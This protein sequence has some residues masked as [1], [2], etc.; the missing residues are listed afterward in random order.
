MALAT[1]AA[2]GC[3]EEDPLDQVDDLVEAATTLVR[4]R[5]TDEQGEPL[6]GLCR[7]KSSLGV[8][9]SETDR[10][11]WA[12]GRV[13]LDAPA[14]VEA[15]APGRFL[16]AVAI[17]ATEGTAVHLALEPLAPREGG[18]RLDPAADAPELAPETH[19]I[20]AVLLG[21]TWSAPSLVG[22][23]AGP[24]LA[25]SP[26]GT[27]GSPLYVTAGGSLY[28]WQGQAWKAIE[29]TATP[30][31]ELLV[32][33]VTDGAVA[34]DAAGQAWWARAA[35]GQVDVCQQEED[36]ACEA[37]GAGV[38]VRLDAREMPWL[39]VA[40]EQ[41]DRQWFAG[42]PWLLQGAEKLPRDLAVSPLVAAR[43]GGAWQLQAHPDGRLELV[44]LDGLPTR[45]FTRD[46]PLKADHAPDL[47][48]DDDRL[49]SALASGD[50]IQA[51][52]TDNDALTWA[53]ETVP[54]QAAAVAGPA[55][56]VQGGDVAIAYYG[57]D[58]PGSP[59]T[60]GGSWDV[61]VAR[62]V[63]GPLPGWVEQRVLR[64]VHDGPLCTRS[65]AD[66]VTAPEVATFAG[67][68][69]DVLFHGDEV[70]VAFN[71]DTEGASRAW[72]VRGAPAS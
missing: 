57:T 72:S 28:A 64:G 34:V 31:R 33:E 3:V 36:W 43:D 4:C 61:Y 20:T 38:T 67:Q 69:L 71:D 40:G 41:G 44:R 66:C 58:R 7:F 15:A 50:R 10:D 47:A 45:V 26:E 22:R 29:T 68:A 12:S 17:H 56:A 11:G 54:S 21:T 13:A 46:V 30:A 14:V 65:A 53:I 24:R 42:S 51:V 8:A 32:D 23:G 25:T 37:I 19:N 5:L 18:Y 9:S 6:A 49:W 1:V 16:R 59:E 48:V 27:A 60:N 70:V 35:G 52:R 63:P 39:Y 55:V 2:A 62:I